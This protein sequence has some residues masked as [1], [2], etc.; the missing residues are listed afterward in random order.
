MNKLCYPK[1]TLGVWVK[2][3]KAPSASS[4][5]SAA[6]GMT[7]IS[8]W[9]HL[10]QSPTAP[11]ASFGLEE[12]KRWH[13]SQ[14]SYWASGYQQSVRL[15]GS[16]ASNASSHK[17]FHASSYFQDSDSDPF[18]HFKIEN[19]KRVAS[20]TS[21]M[22]TREPAVVTGFNHKPRWPLS[23]DQHQDLIFGTLKAV[24]QATIRGSQNLFHGSGER[25]RHQANKYCVLT[26]IHGQRNTWKEPM[27][28]RLEADS[29]EA[30]E[31]RLEADSTGCSHWMH[32]MGV[33]EPAVSPIYLFHALKPSCS[34]FCVPK[35]R[36]FYR[37][38]SLVFQEELK[39]GDLWVMHVV[40]FWLWLGLKAAALARL[41]VA[42]AQ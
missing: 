41:G 14:H 6:S 24:M 28:A 18:L 38:L 29:M 5:S 8:L 3:L 9:H 12:S 10:H 17:A 2:A 35:R 23:Q 33:L 15:K 7:F 40:M 16:A 37:R 39:P 26:E 30:T 20:N 21:M 11:P 34:A 1:Y 42:L 32:P 22:A 13:W 31:A 19:E 27:E 36:A 25:M 4:R